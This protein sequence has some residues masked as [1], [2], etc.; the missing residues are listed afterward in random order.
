MMAFSIMILFFQG[1]AS[2]WLLLYEGAQ[3]TPGDFLKS[4]AASLRLCYNRL[5]RKSEQV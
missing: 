2:I 4:F 1:V 3:F 5:W